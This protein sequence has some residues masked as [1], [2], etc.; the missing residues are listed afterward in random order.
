MVFV[1]IF[2]DDGLFDDAYEA[3]RINQSIWCWRLLDGSQCAPEPR[4]RD[5]DE[6][7]TRR[8]Y[9][10]KYILVPVRVHL[11]IYIDR[12]RDREEARS[13]DRASPFTDAVQSLLNHHRCRP[14]RRRRRPRRPA[15][16]ASPSSWCSS[17][18]NSPRWRS[19]ARAI[20]A[21]LRIYSA[22]SSSVG[23]R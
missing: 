11:Y 13:D 22:T 8:L 6:R 15:R 16:S 3:Q 23:G 19:N 10:D 17:S 9:D 4:R 1:P 20:R 12:D 2:V 14:R 7:S 21:R 5:D 18:S